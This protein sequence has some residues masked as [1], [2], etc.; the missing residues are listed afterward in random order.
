VSYRV[1]DRSTEIG[2]RTLSVEESAEMRAELVQ[3]ARALRAEE[4]K[5]ERDA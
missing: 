2:E 1:F 5:A 4:G 3:V